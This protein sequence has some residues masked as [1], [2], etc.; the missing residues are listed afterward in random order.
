MNIVNFAKRLF[1]TPPKKQ[2]TLED[3]QKWMQEAIL[4]LK[5]QNPAEAQ[6]LMVAIRRE[7]STA[8]PSKE[9]VIRVHEMVMDSLNREKLILETQLP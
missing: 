5:E 6:R 9:L 2:C 1:G 8:E 4:L 7:I 3:Q